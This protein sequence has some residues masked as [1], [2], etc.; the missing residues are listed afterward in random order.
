MPRR[1]TINSLQV[2][3]FVADPASMNHLGSGMH[4]DFASFTDPTYGQAGKRVIP[5]GTAVQQDTT[6]GAFVP[7]TTGRLLLLVTDAVEDSRVAAVSGYG[8][9]T[10]GNVYLDLLPASTQAKAAALDPH[11]HAQVYKDVR[12]GN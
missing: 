7:H 10:G 8:A 6:K 4:V 9:Y 1:N 3:G 12:G 11:F 5:A 2:A